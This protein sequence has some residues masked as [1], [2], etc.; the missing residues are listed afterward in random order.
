VAPSLE[1]GVRLPLHLEPE[2]AEEAVPHHVLDDPG[3]Q[4]AQG[5]ALVGGA[6]TLLLARSS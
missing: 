1:V 5:C 6:R 2:P 4:S 3:E